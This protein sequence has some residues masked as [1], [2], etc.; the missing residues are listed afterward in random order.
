MELPQ[1]LMPA[2]LLRRYKRFL[3]DVR[4]DDGRELTVHC[5]NSG[6]MRGC[7]QPGSRVLISRSDNPGRK[8]PWTLEMVAGPDGWI[9]V[10]TNLTNHL[11]AEAL[12]NGVIDAFGPLAS[13]R[14]E[15]K[16][17][18]HSRLDF[19][20][21]TRE[22]PVYLEVKNCSL[23]VGGV[24]MFPDA[25]T[26]RG[27]KH[28]SELCRLRT[29]GYGAAVLF[30]VQRQDARCFAPAWQIDPE[31]GRALVLARNQGVKIL[32]YQAELDPRTIR[33]V[34]PLPINLEEL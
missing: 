21:E 33:L 8:Y 6:S 19:L 20:L 24:A 22:G 9:G 17:S 14:R 23:A 28:L 15:V 32:A 3:A 1:P 30:C 11:V 7:S 5:P 12:E 26:K 2:R 10:N 29:E 31:Y 25:V 13:L 34:A 27:S 18:E 4:L 16:V